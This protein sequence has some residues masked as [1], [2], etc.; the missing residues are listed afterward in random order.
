MSLKQ[1][2]QDFSRN[3]LSNDYFDLITNHH[4]NQC[5]KFT[6]GRRESRGGE[7]PQLVGRPMRGPASQFP[8]DRHA[9]SASEKAVDNGL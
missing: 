4:V 1:N 7:S 2:I 6:L 8:I 9:I 5:T 3:M